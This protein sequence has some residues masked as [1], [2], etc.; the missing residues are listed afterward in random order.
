MPQG[1]REGDD[2]HRRRE[3]GEEGFELEVKLAGRGGD[4]KRQCCWGP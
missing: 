2:H 3:A 1:M 4:C